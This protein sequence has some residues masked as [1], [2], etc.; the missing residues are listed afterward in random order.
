M[1]QISIDFFFYQRCYTVVKMTEKHGITIPLP[2]VNIISPIIIDDDYLDKIEV[3]DEP[4]VDKPIVDEF[5]INNVSQITDD[6]TDDIIDHVIINSVSNTILP[7]P[8]ILDVICN[9]NVSNILLSFF[10]SYLFNI[11]FISSPI[12]YIYCSFHLFHGLYLY[13]TP[14][15]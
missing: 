3:I 7:Y 4:T 8:H 9:K 2:F 15:T 6:V 10:Y 1:S 5:V 13:F 12:F 11:F 14:I